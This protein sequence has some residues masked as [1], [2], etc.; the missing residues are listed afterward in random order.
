[1]Q[2]P[3]VADRGQPISCPAASR[4]RRDRGQG[5]DMPGPPGAACPASPAGC[6]GRPWGRAEGA[7]GAAT[8]PSGWRG[9]SPREE[10]GSETPPLCGPCM[11]SR[12]LP[13]PQHGAAA[14]VAAATC[15]AS[16]PNPGALIRSRTLTT[17]PDLLMDSC[18]CGN[19]SPQLEL[20]SALALRCRH[21]LPT[22]PG[23]RW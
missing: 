1:M 17:G 2:F 6:V 4:G 11:G 19:V 7:A 10:R 22:P 14:D 23:L 8:L 9:G 20:L 18:P 16:S 15:L 12:R 3:P 21:C 5:P 13:V